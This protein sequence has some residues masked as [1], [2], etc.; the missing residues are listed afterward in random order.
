MLE[1][2]MTECT[3]WPISI[4]ARF[5]Q[6]TNVVI[7]LFKVISYFPVYSIDGIVMVCIAYFM[8]SLRASF[9]AFLQ[10]KQK[11]KKTKQKTKKKKKNKKK[12]QFNIAVAL[13]LLF[14]SVSP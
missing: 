13:G 5:L 6:S 1:S 12:K 10:K 7:D 11:N 9:G 8:I 2:I 14:S 4:S 3:R